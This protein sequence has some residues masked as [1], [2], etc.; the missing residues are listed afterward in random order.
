MK[1]RPCN[2]A[3]V[4]R[5][6]LQPEHNPSLGPS[7]AL[8]SSSVAASAIAAISDGTDITWL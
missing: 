2:L 4:R 3:A 7:F 8:L 1:D 5:E 6:C